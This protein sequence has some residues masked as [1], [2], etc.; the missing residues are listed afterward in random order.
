MRGHKTS[1]CYFKASR[2]I[3]VALPD[4]VCKGN[5]L[6]TRGENDHV[7]QDHDGFDGR[8]YRIRVSR[9]RWKQWY[10]RHRVH[11]QDRS[12]LHAAT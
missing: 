1:E 4:L 12:V 7:D 2:G 11:L 9:A 10:S 3:N 6:P 8:C 5:L